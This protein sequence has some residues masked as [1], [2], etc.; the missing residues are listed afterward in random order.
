MVNPGKQYIVRVYYVS[1]TQ[2]NLRINKEKMLLK[3]EMREEM[4][5]R[6]LEIKDNIKK[7]LNI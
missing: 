1:Y 4:F 3:R 7:V 5:I 2:K 6:N